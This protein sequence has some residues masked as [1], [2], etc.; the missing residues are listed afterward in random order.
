MTAYRGE[1]W[2]ANLNPSR[3]TNEIG[4]IRPVVVLQNN[5][6]AI[7]GYPTTVIMPL[8]T[9]LIDD[10]CPIR[11]R[12]SQRERLKRDSDIVISQVKAIDNSRFIEKIAKL[13]EN[14]LSEILSCLQEIIS[15]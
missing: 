7:N 13:N 5:N 12:I 6:L 9:Q 1:I 11:M 4:K 8:T 10:A 15:P 2:L 3:K 14:E